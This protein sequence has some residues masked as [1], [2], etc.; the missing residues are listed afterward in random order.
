MDLQDTPEIR[1]L[2][3]PQDK[4]LWMIVVLVPGFPPVTSY[5]VPLDRVVEAIEILK[6]EAF[7]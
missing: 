3:A 5:S 2:I 7:Q 1:V 4:R 6:S